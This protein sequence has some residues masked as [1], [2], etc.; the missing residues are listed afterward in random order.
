MWPDQWYEWHNG[1]CERPM[2][3]RQQQKLKPI[4]YQHVNF[5]ADKRREDLMAWAT[6]GQHLNGHIKF[7]MSTERGT[8][9][10]GGRQMWMRDAQACTLRNVRWPRSRQNTMWDLTIIANIFTWWK[11]QLK[12]I[13]VAISEHSAD[14]RPHIRSIYRSTDAAPHP[15]PPIAHSRVSTFRCIVC[16]HL[17]HRRS[18][19]HTHTGVHVYHKCREKS[20]RLASASQW[21]RQYVALT[22]ATMR[23]RW[24]RCHSCDTQICEFN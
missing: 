4:K 23:R 17:S 14:R 11:W 10:M 5:V 16:R 8:V 18:H 20:H 3:R 13:T 7:A 22:M 2:W 19:I 24:R 21:L 6:P 12:F 1:S 9:T 15:S